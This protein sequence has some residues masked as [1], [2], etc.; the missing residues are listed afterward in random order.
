VVLTDLVHAAGLPFVILHANFQLRGEESERDQSFVEGL[1]DRYKAIVVSNRFD[2]KA[3]ARQHQVSIQVA[4]RD[5]RY[6]WF[7]GFLQKEEG[8]KGRKLLVTAHHADDNVETLLQHFFQGTGIAGLRGMLP[9]SDLAVHPLLFVRR[10]ELEAYAKERGLE[11][12][13]DS[14]NAEV[15]YTRN[16]LRHQLIPAIESVFPGA[17]NNL[18]RN[19]GRFRDIE[20]LYERAVERE[21]KKL[22]FVDKDEWKVPVE[23]LRRAEPL[24]TLAW[25]LFSPFGFTAHQVPE[26]IALMDSGSGRFIHSPTHRLL[27]NRNWFIL[28]PGQLPVTGTFIVEEGQGELLFPAGSLVFRQDDVTGDPEKTADPSLACLDAAD[29]RYPLL[30]RPW[31]NGD[32]FYPFGMRKKKKVAR[33]LIDAKLSRS[34]KEKVWVLESDKR[35]LWVIGHRIDD[36]FRLGPGTGSRLEIRFMAR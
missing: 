16:A 4:A 13:E 14:S 3:F 7:R 9:V 27:K 23:K 31:K 30:V 11:W 19:L 5:L 32:Y 22:I 33:F 28:S 1:G 15:K 24:N 6:G 34:E 20:V 8:E 35:I 12:V 10:Q 36:R 2:T 25:E 29:I 18:A 21:L 26:I 17:A